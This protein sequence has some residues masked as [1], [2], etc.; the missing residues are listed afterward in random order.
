[1]GMSSYVLDEQD[2]AAHGNGVCKTLGCY[3]GTQ[4]LT[5]CPADGYRAIQVYRDGNPIELGV[6]DTEE[7]AEACARASHAEQL[8]DNGQFGVGA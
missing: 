8:A 2:R 6:F 7:E 4:P 3:F 1:M 5:D